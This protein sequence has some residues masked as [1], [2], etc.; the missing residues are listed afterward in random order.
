[1]KNFKSFITE[2]P[3]TDITESV[4]TDAAKALS[5][6]KSNERAA[7]KKYGKNW[8]TVLY[9][10]AFKKFGGSTQSE[11]VE[12]ES[13]ATLLNEEGRGDNFNKGTKKSPGPLQKQSD[14]TKTKER[15]RDE[16]KRVKTRQRSERERAEISDFRAKDMERKERERK[17]LEKIKKGVYEC[18]F[19]EE[20]YNSVGNTKFETLLRNGLVKRSDLIRF[21]L[22]LEKF[23][24]NQTPTLIER[25]VFFNV[26]DRLVGFVT[27]DQAL[28]TKIHQ[29]AVQHRK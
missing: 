10:I 9:T 12:E 4:V 21:K 5:F 25:E 24:N 27:Q 3:A 14:L 6:V 29:K 28:Y 23:T 19:I 11:S 2:T 18:V 22:A 1:M 8:E 17:R 13:S 20:L 16:D 26:F 15:H 7:Q